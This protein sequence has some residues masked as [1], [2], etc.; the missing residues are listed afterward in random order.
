MRLVARLLTL[1]TLAMV[2]PT[3]A[4]EPAPAVQPG[5]LRSAGWWRD[6]AVHFADGITDADARGKAH[7]ELVYVQGFAGDFE[8]ARAS[9]RSIN[10]PQLCIYAHV[11]LA[12]QYEASGDD[13]ACQTQ[14]Q[15]AG[16]ITLLPGNTSFFDVIRRHLELGQP[17]QAISLA[18][19]IPHEFHRNAAFQDIAATLAGQGKLEMAR[20]IVKKHL[21]PSWEQSG[22]SVMANACADAL[23]IDEAQK[24]AAKLT[25]TKLQDRAYDHLVKALVKAGRAAEAGSFADRI[26]DATL[27]ATARAQITANMAKKQNAQVLRSRVEKATTREEKLALYDLLFAELV[28][29]GDV[30]AAEAAIESMVEIVKASPR[31]AQKSKFGVFDDAGL[32]AKAQANYL[33]TAKLLAA[34]GDRE[35]SLRRTARA[36][37]AI[38]EL[39]DESGLLK[40]MLV[41]ALVASEIDAGDFHGART[42]LAQLKQ[43]YGQSSAAADVAAGLIKSGDVKSG[44]EVAE[45][46]TEPLG[47]DRAMGKV[48]SALL[49]AGQLDEAKNLLR[50]I[51]DGPNEVGAFRIVGQTMV[52]LGRET[53][54][55]QW[56]GELTSKTACAYLCMGAADVLAKRQ[57][58]KARSSSNSRPARD[59]ALPNRWTVSGVR[60]HHD[61]L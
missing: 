32:I 45:L 53:E 2:S 58:G 60:E 22:W 15:E 59:L 57:A 24:L 33:A 16:E 5:Q 37:K 54:L 31:P 6:Q 7:Y 27:Q 9:I 44:L 20:D 51:G 11:F 18:G 55:H 49:R 17:A 48:A 3:H 41:P 34:K 46:I 40:L 50:K 4:A 26:S 36:R 8:G 43:G 56:L 47:K 10:N 23:R 61:C 39:P 29:A 52:E 14:L 28:A 30:A 25:D 12:K 42:T 19:R 21:P 38:A 35:G 13:N 1:G